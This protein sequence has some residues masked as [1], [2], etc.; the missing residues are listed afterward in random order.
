MG[1]YGSDW[2][3]GGYFG[4]GCKE[5]IGT[6]DG[7]PVIVAG[8]GFGV[9]KQVTDAA[10][11]LDDPCYFAVNDV[12]MYINPLDHWVTLHVDNIGA[13]K[14]VRW[15]HA[16]GGEGTKYHSIDSRVDVDYVWSGLTPV[17]ALSG[18]FAMQIA[19]IMGA[20]IIVLCGCPGDLT[21]RFFEAERSSLAFGYG[22]G[23]TGGDKG[24]KEQLEKEMNRLPQFKAKVRSMSGWTQTY[25]GGL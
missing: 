17:F 16:K 23:A 9:F 3:A 7:R 4:V 12:G 1:S 20:G 5:L 24:I 22:G 2:E 10:K 14:D 6:L 11:K 13:W 21:P 25:F 18:Y 8:N 15:L 19:Y